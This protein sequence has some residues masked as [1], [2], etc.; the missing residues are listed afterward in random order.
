MA[1]TELTVIEPGGFLALNHDLD[2]VTGFIEDNLSG[3]EVTEFDLK[4]ISVPSGKATKYRWEL[5]TLE[6]SEAVD[7][8]T[9]IIV[10]QKQTRQ[11]WPRSIDDGGGNVPPS[12]SSPDGKVGFGKQWATKDDI[13]PPGEPRQLDCK[14]CPK[15]QFGSDG[16]RGQ[17]CKQSASLFLLME[18]GFLPAVVSVPPTSLRSLKHYMLGLADVGIRYDQVVTTLALEKDSNAGGTEYAVIVPRL[19]GRLDP[20][21]A[22]KA[23]AYGAALRPQ[24]EAVATQMVTEPAVPM[25]DAGMGDGPSDPDE[26]TEPIAP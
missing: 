5:P 3:Q 8:I 14:A 7:E 22:V 24:F 10:F 4:R 25:G 15:S 20:D 13:D 1:S 18:T 17:A 23:R 16:G 21:D 6:G 11:F 26:R 2:E 19:G 12:C 9:G